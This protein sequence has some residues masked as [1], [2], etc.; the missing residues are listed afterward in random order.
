[1]VEFKS[2]EGVAASHPL[3]KAEGVGAGEPTRT[4]V[5]SIINTLLGMANSQQNLMSSL[6]PMATYLQG[7]VKRLTED[8]KNV[9]NPTDDKAGVTV[10]SRDT[11]AINTQI[12]I[13]NQ[14]CQTLNSQTVEPLVQGEAGLFQMVSSALGSI[15]SIRF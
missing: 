4:N 5:W 1:M 11:A 2:T 6:V 12:S 3:G 15:A 14:A 10:F 8:L 9:P 7:A 13:F